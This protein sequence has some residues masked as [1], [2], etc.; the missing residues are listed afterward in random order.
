MKL[1]K[2][3]IL[4]IAVVVTGTVFAQEAK[5]VNV[6]KEQCLAKKMNKKAAKLQKKLTKVE[7]KA[8]EAHAKS[9]VSMSALKQAVADKKAGK[10]AD[11]KTYQDIL[12][13]ANKESLYVN[14]V[15]DKV[16]AMKGKLS[17]AKE[18]AAMHQKN[19][20]AASPTK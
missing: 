16:N 9:D 12:T 1:V 18:R 8:S 20:E 2:V 6:K 7:Q 11:E 3:I 14:D 13:K 4:V 19:A 10:L 15:T 5:P 17:K